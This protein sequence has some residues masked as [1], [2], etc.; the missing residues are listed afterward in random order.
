MLRARSVSLSLALLLALPATALG[1]A[2]EVDETRL[3][4]LLQ[5]RGFEPPKKFK[6]LVGKVRL[7]ADGPPTMDWYDWRGTSDDRDDWWPASS[8]KIYAAVAALERAR[9]LGFSP[10]AWVT[11]HYDERPSL[12]GQDAEP[13]KGRLSHLVHGA[14][15]ASNNRA[16]NRLVELVGFDRLNDEFF[17][18]RNGLGRTTFLRAYFAMLDD[19]QTGHGDNR[20]SPRITLAYRGDSRELPARKGDRRGHECPDQG[21]CTTLRELAEH[22]RRVMLHDRLPEAQRYDLD[23]AE[24]ELLRE[25]LEAPRKEHGQLLV[26]AVQ[27][28]FGEDV[29]LRIYHK[30]GYA[31]RWSSDVM[32][33]H[34][35]DTKECW[36]VALAGWPGRRVI[37][38]A[39]REIGALLASGE[40]TEATA[41]GD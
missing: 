32:F 2:A 21:N 36:I 11:Y 26:E 39:L 8:V 33:I 24:L 25:A 37:D 18:T 13:V 35:T 16:F 9:A 27:A 31:Y 5:A 34:R 12:W 3:A 28:G 17:T 19:P 30:P 20:Y 40:L 4:E 6:A 38:G 29:P 22:I 1:Q 23:D 14:I 15:V 10:E 41:E 7:P